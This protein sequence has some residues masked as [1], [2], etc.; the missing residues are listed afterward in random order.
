MTSA[1][2][3]K[4]VVGRRV[5][6][7]YYSN[8]HSDS[9]TVWHPGIITALEP[10]L[11]G[12]LLALIRLD[13]KRSTLSIPLDY[14]GLAYLDEV[15][16]VPDL[17]MGPFIPTATYPHPGVLVE[18]AGVLVTAVGED[19]GDLIAITTDRTAAETAI[20]ERAVEV[21]FDVDY[22]DFD[23]MQAKWGVFDWEPYDPDCPWAADDWFVRWD[24]AES[25]EKAVHIFHLADA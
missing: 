19:G 6:F 23:R 10:G 16:P 11:T 7:A 5:E 1:L 14:E 9:E 15:V 18:K 22:L 12:A 8:L 13:G 3:E 20:R 4:A 24:A 21:G 25:D 2:A 17:P